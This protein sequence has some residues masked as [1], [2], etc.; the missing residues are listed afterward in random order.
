MK[1]FMALF[2]LI[3]ALGGS[4]F[5]GDVATLVNLGFS[6][7]SAYFMFGYYG[8]D[9]RAGKPYAEAYIVD[10]RKNDYVP[11]G[12]WKGMY[13]ADLQPGWNPAGG[14]YKLFSDA[15][16]AA[17]KYRIDHLSQGRLIYLLLNGAD[18]PDALSFK[19]FDT[20][21]QWDVALRE[22]VEEKG[23]EYLSS[24]GLDVSVT[25]PDGRK[26]SVS[27]GNPS[28]RRKGVAGYTIRQILV[29]PDGKTVVMLVE[30]LEKNASGVAIRY[31]VESF[32]LP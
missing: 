8:L 30:K 5:A 2:A 25:A 18:G 1:K 24:F 22:T 6:P 21:D 10:T 9:T 23:G 4:A 31:M 7:D 32:R 26:V 20:G 11:G 19:D 13:G 14:F 17:R 15:V 3:A 12:A 29:A 28:I 16:P 27:A